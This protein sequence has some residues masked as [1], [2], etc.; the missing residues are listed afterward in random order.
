MRPVR[1]VV[2]KAAEM[3]AEIASEATEHVPGA[4]L[5]ALV[6]RVRHAMRQEQQI[7]HVRQPRPRTIGGPSRFAIGSGSRF[8]AAM[9]SRYF[10]LS[11]LC[12]GTACPGASR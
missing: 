11:G 10:G 5:L 7:A 8:H 2:H 3:N 12:S 6:G 9:N 1:H 4:D